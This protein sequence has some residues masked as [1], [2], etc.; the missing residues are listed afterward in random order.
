M[1]ILVQIDR[2]LQAALVDLLP[3]VAVPVEQTDRDK[4][5]IEITGGFA[6]IARENAEAARIVGDRFMETKFRGKIRDRFFN[7]G[8]SAGFSISVLAFEILFKC[9]VDLFQFAEK[10][11]VLGNFLK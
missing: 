11:F 3:E 5:E 1:K 2:V 10:S 4:V 7:R 6:M 9:V 8:A